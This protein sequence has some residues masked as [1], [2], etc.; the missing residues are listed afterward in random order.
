MASALPTA[1]MMATAEAW[2]RESDRL[3]ALAN[4]TQSADH[5]RALHDRAD[6]ALALHDRAFSD[7]RML[8]PL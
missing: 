5:A 2:L 7:P 8:P 6:G 4:R 1:R 3:R